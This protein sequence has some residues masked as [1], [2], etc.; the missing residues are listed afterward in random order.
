MPTSSIRMTHG[1]ITS[2]GINPQ[3]A[4]AAGRCGPA[5]LLFGSQGFLILGQHPDIFIAVRVEVSRR[6]RPTG[7]TRYGGGPFVG[8]FVVQHDHL[9]AALLLGANVLI[10]EGQ[11]KVGAL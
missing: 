7:R 8:F 11:V 4:A 5:I 10:P 1:A 3:S 2:A 9:A 6:C